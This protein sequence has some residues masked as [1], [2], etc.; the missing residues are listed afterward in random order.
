MGVPGMDGGAREARQAGSGSEQGRARR[1]GPARVRPAHAHPRISLRCPRVYPTYLYTLP[2]S[3][4][5]PPISC[6]PE[7]PC[8]PRLS[9]LFLRLLSRPS[10]SPQVL[11]S[12]PRAA[13]T[14]SALAA[15]AA[16][17]FAGWEAVAVTWQRSW[18]LTGLLGGTAYR[19]V[20]RARNTVLPD[21]GLPS[22]VLLART[23]PLPP[24][25]VFPAP[26]ASA[27]Q[28]AAAVG[29]ALVNAS[30]ATAG[31]IT[32]FRVAYADVGGGGAAAA[33]PGTQLCSGGPAATGCVLVGLTPGTRYAVTVAASNDPSLSLF[34]PAR[35]GSSPVITA[36]GP[37]FV[38]NAAAAAASPGAAA[39]Q[40]TA[41]LA[42]AAA[43]NFSVT[44]LD[45]AE[46]AAGGAGYTVPLAAAGCAGGRLC[47]T[48]GGLGPGL[49]YTFA[50]T[51]VT[52]GGQH[53]S[54]PA[55]PILTLPAAPAA[56]TVV[57]RRSSGLDV[58]IAAWEG[59][60]RVARYRLQV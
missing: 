17:G 55:A 13:A 35:A 19:F 38:F 43:A 15:A 45:E 8:T 47:A 32:G 60:N 29:W 59:R 10:L 2:I 37:P 39:L 49:R 54:A 21:Y 14:A 11:L 36:P 22:D 23:L 24:P 16:A 46:A 44:V 1:R 20:A 53:T 27:A 58:V 40:W 51:A 31:P 6:T 34:G 7:A 9:P 18:V 5:T 3:A 4:C 56:P 33:P 12:P 57:G 50:V 41:R 26:N 52:A 28:T 42:G 25:A 48:V 30:A